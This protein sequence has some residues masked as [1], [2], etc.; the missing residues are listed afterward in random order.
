MIKPLSAAACLFCLAAPAAWAANEVYD[1]YSVMVGEQNGRLM[2]SPCA[3][4]QTV[5]PAV[6]KRV[7]DET[8]IRAALKTHP[9]RAGRPYG[10]F[11]L[12]VIGAPLPA[13]AEQNAAAAA[14]S[15]A[16]D[17]WGVTGFAVGEILAQTRG[18]CYLPDV[19][20]QIVPQ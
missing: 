15:A 2:V 3:D 19:L 11:H 14:S 7:E 8:R 16:A 13:D 1:L 4:P 6:F 17:E 20:E 12:R 18:S 10:G 5:W 9:P